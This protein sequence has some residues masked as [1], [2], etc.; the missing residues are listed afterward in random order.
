[1]PKNTQAK[2]QQENV[3]EKLRPHGGSETILLVEDDEAVMRM[4]SKIL[5]GNGYHVIEAGNGVEGF[6]VA[7]KGDHP[8]IDLLVTDVIMP[9]MTGKTLSD[10]LRREYPDL[11]V[12][13]ISGYTDNATVRES[14][15]DEGVS[16]L[17]KPFS[18]QSLAEKV[19]DII[20]EN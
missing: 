2:K 11:K 7:T 10:K 19:R 13:F 9:K 5:K 17:Q 15:L 6:A 1:M 3:P 20:D 18:P 16:F 12:L 4:T 8:E 14:L